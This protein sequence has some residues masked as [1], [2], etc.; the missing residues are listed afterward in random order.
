[1]ALL[2][3]FY[4]SPRQS[5]DFSSAG[6]SQ[7]GILANTR[8]ASVEARRYARITLIETV[9]CAEAR[10]CLF[11]LESHVSRQ[12]QTFTVWYIF[13]LVNYIAL[14]FFGVTLRKRFSIRAF[15]IAKAK[16][17]IS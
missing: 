4:A 15:I 10:V 12:K 3:G 16:F 17:S 2:T 13:L 1:M 11:F 6:R 9:V 8:M 5:L 14:P 7:G